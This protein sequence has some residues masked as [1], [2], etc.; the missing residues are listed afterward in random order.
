MGKALRIPRGRVEVFQVDE[1]NAKKDTDDR[2]LTLIERDLGSALGNAELHAMPVGDAMSRNAQRYGTLL[3]ERCGTPPVFDLVH[4]GL[5]PDGHTAS[6]LPDHSVLDVKD[7][8][9]TT[10]SKKGELA[11]MTMT[12]PVLDLARLV[13]FVVT[14]LQKAEAVQAVLRGDRSMPAARLEAGNVLFLLDAGA[15]SR[16]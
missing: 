3:E 12:F 13:V 2:N 4:L 10:V 11:R 5:G 8:W 16:L 7:T 14:G 6:L 1:R 15:A 9:V